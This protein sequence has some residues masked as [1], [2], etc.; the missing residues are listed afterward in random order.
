MRSYRQGA[1]QAYGVLSDYAYLVQGLIDLYESSFEIRWL[2]WAIELQKKQ[3]ELFWDSAQ[4]AYFDTTGRDATILLRMKEDYDGAEPAPNSTAA[5][6]LQRLSHLLDSKEWQAK[7]QQTLSAFATQLKADPSGMP[8]MLVALGFHY[9]KPKQII[10]AGNLE[11]DDT[12]EMLREVHKQYL[13]NKILMLADNGEGQRF[14]SQHIPFI[15]SV[16]M[17]QG[18]ATAY[19][20]ENYVCQ[21]PTSDLGVMNRLLRGTDTP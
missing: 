10:I 8:Q 19:V 14:L 16:K 3:D 7:A 9:D 13:P 20:C 2:T 4:G 15:G 1:G 11:H 21:L 18:R 12:K 6:N 5:L 17:H